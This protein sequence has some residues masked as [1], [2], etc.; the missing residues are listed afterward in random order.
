MIDERPP[1]VSICI[2]TLRGYDRLARL[3][4]SIEQHT[5]SVD[6]EVVIVEN[7]SRARGYTIP[8][9]Q[10]LRAG[11]G[12]FLIALNDDVEV[13]AGWIGPLVEQ[14]RAGVWACTP[15]MTHTDGPQVFAPYCLCLRREAFEEF[16]GLDERFL[17]W[18]S[19]IDLARRLVEAGHPPVKV[20]LPNPILH[21]LNATTG[22]HPELGQV[23]LGDLA[24]YR[25]KW[26]VDA[27][28]DKARLAT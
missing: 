4:R 2:P 19:D 7:G 15:D 18:C 8:M 11:R 3:L 1:E 24:R 6:Y 12:E 17:L 27:E 21:E 25:E 13:T 14:A 16:D 22:E 23:C 20:K 5:T 26:G 9:N 28:S 10:A